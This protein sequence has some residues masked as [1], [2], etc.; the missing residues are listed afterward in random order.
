MYY[1]HCEQIVNRAEIAL[2]ELHECQN[3]SS[4][5][6]RISAPI[7]FGNAILLP[8]IKQLRDLYPELNIDLQLDDRIVNIVEQG[9]DLTLRVGRLND[10]NLIAKI[11]QWYLHYRNI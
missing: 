7:P 8:V 3:Q 6:L 2:D 1:R 5:T 10:S 4:G 11:R 9:I